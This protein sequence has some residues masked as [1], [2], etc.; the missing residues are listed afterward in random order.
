MSVRSNVEYNFFPAFLCVARPRLQLLT[1][2]EVYDP[3]RYPLPRVRRRVVSSGRRWN[4]LGNALERYDANDVERN[5]SGYFLNRKFY[6]LW[7]GNKRG[8][9]GRGRGR[10]RR[11]AKK[12]FGV[13]AK[14][15]TE[16]KEAGRHAKRCSKRHSGCR[17]GGDYSKKKKKKK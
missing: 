11:V 2:D 9:G 6:S 16:G 7:G 8:R 1:A 14:R 5:S 15:R 17:V 12:L 13:C 4:T 10:E 3:D